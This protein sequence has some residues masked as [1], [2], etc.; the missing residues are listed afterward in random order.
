MTRRFPPIVPTPM[1][2]ANLRFTSPTL[3]IARKIFLLAVVL[4]ATASSQSF[5]ADAKPAAP[6]PSTNKALAELVK[7]GAKLYYLGNY[8]GLDGWL[9]VKDGKVQTVYQSDKN[10]FMMAGYLFAPNGDNITGEQVKKL[11]A[12]N[13]EVAQFVEPSPPK[14]TP[15]ETAKAATKETKS[16]DQQLSAGERALKELKPNPGVTLGSKAD[17]PILF[18]LISPGLAE[19]KKF[20]LDIRDEVKKGNLRVRLFPAGIRG[21]DDERAAAMLLQSKDPLTAWDKFADGDVKA[22]A[23]TPDPASIAK[24]D[25]NTAFITEWRFPTAPYI[26]YRGKDGKV[27]VVQGQPS[28]PKTLLGDAAPETPET[29]KP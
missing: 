14:D 1:Q 20:W 29:V 22:L 3:N 27:K 28:D 18:V 15:K 26:L 25:I 17:A 5:A 2:N 12:E 13:K 19:C 21:T 6:D 4:V 16:G 7:N 23:G 8:A 11:A 9:A 10:T 24:A